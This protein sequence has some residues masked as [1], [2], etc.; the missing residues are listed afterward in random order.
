VQGWTLPLDPRQQPGHATWL[1]TVVH[2]ERTLESTLPA[3]PPASH[4]LARMRGSLASVGSAA[5]PPPPGAFPLGKAEPQRAPAQGSEG[6]LLCALS[7]I[8]HLNAELRAAA[9]ATAEGEAEREERRERAEREAVEARAEASAFASRFDALT[10]ARDAAEEEARGRGV[11]EEGMRAALEGERVA[12]R[13]ARERG[14]ALE[15]RLAVATAALARAREEEEVLCRLAEAQAGRWAPSLPLTLAS[16][17]TGTL[18]PALDSLARAGC[19]RIAE[20]CGEVE[21]LSQALDRLR[22]EAGA[23][24]RRLRAVCVGVGR[25]PEADV[26]LGQSALDGTFAAAVGAWEAAQGRAAG[27]GGPRDPLPVALAP[28]LGEEG[29]TSPVPSFSAGEE[30]AAVAHLKLCLAR[31]LARPICLPPAPPLP[32]PFLMGGG[33]PLEVSPASLAL[34]LAHARAR[35]RGECV[36]D[37]VA[38][39]E[40]G[41]GGAGDLAEAAAI[42]RAAAASA[43]RE[44]ARLRGA[45]ASIAVAWG[46]AGARAEEALLH[47]IQRERVATGAIERA[48]AAEARVDGLNATIVATENTAEVA[49]SAAVAEAAVQA[50]TEAEGRVQRRLEAVRAAGRTE[51]AVWRHV[52]RTE[53]AGRRAADARLLAAVGGVHVAVRVCGPREG[54]VRISATLP[55]TVL[56]EAPSSPASPLPS[57][58]YAFDAVHAGREGGDVRA[59]YRA[60]LRPLL[61]A[62]TSQA[63]PGTLLLYGAAAGAGKA[64]VRDGLAALSLASPSVSALSVWEAHE[65]RGLRDLLAAAAGRGRAGEGGGPTGAYAASTAAIGHGSSWAASL[66]GGAGVEE[67]SPAPRLRVRDSGSV[68]LAGLTSLPCAAGTGTGEVALAAALACAAPPSALVIRLTLSNGTSVH[69]V[70]LP[71]PPAPSLAVLGAVLEAVRAG[72]SG[73]RGAPPPHIPYRDCELT[74]ALRG[75][76]GPAPGAGPFPPSPSLPRVLLLACVSAAPQRLAESVTA[77]RFAS[78]VRG[79]RAAREE[80]EGE[81]EDE[82]GAP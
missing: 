62:A 80:E 30:S 54:G 82:E 56:V 23:E 20:L 22:G 28:L 76:L 4:V 58:A 60:V 3:M 50:Q 15:A 32:P 64:E 16:P 45:L 1:S 72:A 78:R 37:W 29:P 40:G 67:D 6:D 57:S 26:P 81:E 10:S 17:S 77:L 13:E 21:A 43:T 18:L 31:A 25:P 48:E 63:V 38:A 73:K 5:P 68:E 55:S 8:L 36:R 34:L 65:E 74:H 75:G 46:R 53:A 71:P 59:L 69:L 52:A 27:E 66:R 51:Q 41:G 44:C 79:G 61:E 2:E 47:A 7:S 14:E 9:A 70:D 11:V 35:E 49:L 12:C 24:V 19:A 42:A 39:Q 33:G